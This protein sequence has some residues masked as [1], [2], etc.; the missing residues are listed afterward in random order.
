[1]I[2]AH[3]WRSLQETASNLP[4]PAKVLISQPLLPLLPQ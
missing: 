4:Q 3:D 1:M 2:I